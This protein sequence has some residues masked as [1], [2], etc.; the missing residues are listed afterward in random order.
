MLL[1]LTQIINDFRLYSDFQQSYKKT[2]ANPSLF[3]FIEVSFE[4]AFSTQ[5]LYNGSLAHGFTHIKLGQTPKLADLESSGRAILNYL[6]SQQ[7]SVLLD[8]LDFEEGE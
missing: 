4:G 5:L 2:L 6:V 3:T 8:E 1:D 7:Q